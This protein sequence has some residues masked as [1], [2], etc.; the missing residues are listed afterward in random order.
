MLTVAH[1]QTL[2]ESHIAVFEEYRKSE[3]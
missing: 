1:S 2:L 3:V